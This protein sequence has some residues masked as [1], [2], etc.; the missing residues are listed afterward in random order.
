MEVAH[1]NFFVRRVHQADKT[2]TLDF[3]SPVLWFYRRDCSPIPPLN[4][5]PTE[6]VK[7]LDIGSPPFIALN[8]NQSMERDGE[9]G[10]TVRMNA[11]CGSQQLIELT[12]D[13]EAGNEMPP[14]VNVQNNGLSRGTVF[15][16]MALKTQ[17]FYS[18]PAFQ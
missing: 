2:S 5:D 16:S 3:N 6:L 12:L 15:P 11:V 10:K 17:Y 8:T 18:L 9:S 4:K 14:F 7:L 1:R 13:P